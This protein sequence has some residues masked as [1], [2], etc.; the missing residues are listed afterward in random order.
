[1]DTRS[2][3]K[4]HEISEPVRPKVVSTIKQIL[5]QIMSSAVRNL[6]VM[7]HPILLKPD[8]GRLRH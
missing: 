3:E 7:G 1:M 8:P 6:M 4:R 2:P 5:V